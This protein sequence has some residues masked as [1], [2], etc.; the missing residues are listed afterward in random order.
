MADFLQ[1]STS[2]SVCYCQLNYIYS[3]EQKCSHEAVGASL[4]Q[5]QV[6]IPVLSNIA[7]KIWADFQNSLRSLITN[8]SC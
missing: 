4:S 6:L 8:P 1:D 2:E 5:Q 7:L 3:T